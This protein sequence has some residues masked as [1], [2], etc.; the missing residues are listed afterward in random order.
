[1]LISL[2]NVSSIWTHIFTYLV[3]DVIFVTIVIV[4]VVINTAVVIVIVVVI[5]DANFI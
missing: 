1:M 2:R 3:V 4:T 5:A